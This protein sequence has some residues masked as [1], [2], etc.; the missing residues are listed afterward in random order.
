[1]PGQHMNE[2]SGPR[3]PDPAHIAVTAEAVLVTPTSTTPANFTFRIT[4]DSASDASGNLCPRYRTPEVQPETPT[5]TPLPTTSDS[6]VIQFP[7][8]PVTPK[9]HFTFRAIRPCPSRLLRANRLATPQASSSTHPEDSADD[10]LDRAIELGNQAI[11]GLRDVLQER[12]AAEIP[13]PPAELPTVPSYPVSF[14]NNHPGIRDDYRILLEN[15]LQHRLSESYDDLPTVTI[16]QT[17]QH[18]AALRSLDAR[19][20]WIYRW[21][22]QPLF[23]HISQYI[24]RY[25]HHLG[26]NPEPCFHTPTSWSYQLV[27]LHFPELVWSYT[28]AEVI[29][30][31]NWIIDEYY[32]TY[33]LVIKFTTPTLYFPTSQ[34][35]KIP[36]ITD[37]GCYQKPHFYNSTNNQDY[38]HNSEDTNWNTCHFRHCSNCRRNTNPNK[39]AIRNVRQRISNPPD[40]QSIA[41]NPEANQNTCAAFI[42]Y[43]FI[44]SYNPTEEYWSYHYNSNWRHQDFCLKQYCLHRFNGV[45]SE[46]GTVYLQHCGPWLEPEP[47]DDDQLAEKSPQPQEPAPAQTTPVAPIAPPSRLPTPQAHPGPTT[48]PPPVPPQQSAMDSTQLANLI[49]QLTNLTNALTGQQTQSVNTKLQRPENFG[50]DFAD[51]PAFWAEMDAMFTDS[52]EAVT[53]QQTLKHYQFEDLVSKAG[54]SKPMIHVVNLL[55]R[56]VDSKI[57]GMIY[58]TRNPPSAT[59]YDDWKNRITT[60]DT[61][62]CQW[63]AELGAYHHQQPHA[64]HGHTAHAPPPHATPHVPFRPPAQPQVPTRHDATSVTFGGQGQPMDL[65]RLCKKCGSRKRDKGTCRD[66]WHVPNRP[67]AICVWEQG[68]NGLD[69]FM[70]QLR[71]FWAE[72]PEELTEI[73]AIPLVD[74]RDVEEDFYAG[75]E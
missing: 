23:A 67:Q 64:T 7:L 13:E 75:L 8:R 43:Q 32:T 47:A 45:A 6:R 38:Y 33:E 36:S 49:T 57:M 54:Y 21:K 11:A 20:I 70:Q 17:Q 73:L 71:Q 65:D 44:V 48:N 68:D 62:N 24:Y 35:P 22:P 12:L 40:L 27:I 2:N 1:M 14:H 19:Y 51:L 66:R 26:L 46:P 4:N 28:P 16:P 53:A 60:I 18:E 74:D 72:N 15:G 5:S 55:K 56:T 58:A 29:F 52:N 50:G 25:T 59:A 37:L 42:H 34:T 30:R 3:I 61:H 31:T 69:F 39:D 10:H 9:N 63:A 41:S